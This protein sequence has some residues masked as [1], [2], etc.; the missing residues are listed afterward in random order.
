MYIEISS[1]KYPVTLADLRKKFP[2]EALP[3]AGPDAATLE[4]LGYAVVV[5]TD[6]PEITTTQTASEGAPELVDGIW[7][8][9]WVI[10]EKSSAEIAASLLAIKGEKK[11]AARDACQACLTSLV[12]RF[13][14]L[15]MLTWESQRSEAAA[16]LGDTDPTATTYPW[17]GGIIAETGEAFGAFAL[18]VQENNAT[19]RTA[20]T[21]LL[22]Q[23]QKI[24]LA[25]DACT[26]VAEV[27]AVAVTI[28]LPESS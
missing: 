17:I 4:K 7:R 20:A 14:P 12:E 6:L 11:R 9:T 26:T 13:P 21:S 3:N 15:E 2:E 19:F 10:G 24:C 5:A 23:R 18:A 27:E 1:K 22:G 25:I 16:I 28:A 8:Q